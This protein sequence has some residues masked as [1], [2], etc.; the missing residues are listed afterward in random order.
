LIQENEEGSEE[1][2]RGCLYQ[3][4][5]GGMGFLCGGGGGGGG[6]VMGTPEPLLATS[7][8]FSE[9]MNTFFTLLMDKGCFKWV[10]LVK[11]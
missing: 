1:Y 9:K 11:H 5:G 6:G 4:V 8:Q 3:C 2:A 10:S 7:L